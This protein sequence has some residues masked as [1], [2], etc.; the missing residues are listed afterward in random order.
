MGLFPAAGKAVA[1]P[2][3]GARGDR[4][5]PQIHPNP[6]LGLWGPPDSQLGVPNLEQR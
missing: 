2:G 6:N 1:A 3:W 5:P 4:P